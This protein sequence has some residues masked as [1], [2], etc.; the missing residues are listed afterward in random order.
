MN[1]PRFYEVL[2]NKVVVITGGAGVIGSKITECLAMA[3][4]KV[5]I[6]DLTY[7]KGYELEKKL[8]EEGLIVKTYKCNVLDKNEIKEA[9]KN[10]LAD[11]GPCDIL[12]NGAGGNNS[13]AETS[14]EFFTGYKK[15]VIS[16]FDLDREKIEFVFSL[17]YMGTLLTIQEFSKDMINKDSASIINIASMSSFRPLSKVVA[18][19]NAKASVVNLTKWLA[20]YFSKTNIRVNAIAPGF[21]VT[22]QNERLLFNESGKETI[23]GKK[24]L[25]MTPVNRFGKVEELIGSI[26]F[27]ASEEASSFVNGV[28][29]AVDGAFSAYSGV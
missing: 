22:K 17:N 2:E 27:L 4:C 12:I 6:L 21:F 3:K 10:I 9:H 14:D 29:L 15:D 18:Y 23:R 28:V 16:F 19:S 25:S 24:I 1:L 20:V 13:M 7:K 26:I 11:F 5:A 8:K